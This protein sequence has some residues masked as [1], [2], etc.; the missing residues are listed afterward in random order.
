MRLLAAGDIEAYEYLDGRE[1][2]GA[3]YR[4]NIADTRRTSVE[5]DD[6]WA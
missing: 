6:R 1:I 2:F 5:V 4:I 3:D